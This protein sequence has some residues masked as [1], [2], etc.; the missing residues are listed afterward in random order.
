MP[1]SPVRLTR[2]ELV[3]LAGLTGAAAASS[4][5][6]SALGR[7]A[8]ARSGPEVFL[9]EAYALRAQIATSADLP[10]LE[11]IY[12]RSSSALRF[13]RDRAQYM[14]RGLSTRWDGAVLGHRS[15]ITMGAL[16]VNG[17]QAHARLSER[18]ESF[19][20][21]NLRPMSGDA[22]RLRHDNPQKYGVTPI[23]PRGEVAS[24]ALIP[25]EVWLTQA[26]G[27]WRIEKDAHDEFF[28][29]DRSPDLEPGSWAA[30]IHGRPRTVSSRVAPAGKVPGLARP[31]ATVYNYSPAAARAYAQGYAINPH[32][33]YC[34]YNDCGG[35]CTNFVSQC[36]RNGGE[37]DQS[38][39]YTFTGGC[40]TCG[41]S[42]TYAGSDTWANVQ[43]MGDFMLNTGGRASIRFNVD[44]IGYGDH[45]D[46]QWDSGWFDHKTILTGNP[47][48][49]SALVCSHSP[50][51]LDYS[52]N[53]SPLCCASAYRFIW[54]NTSYN[55]P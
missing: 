3:R 5:I 43:L 39:W 32:G 19:W 16:E 40:G 52:W 33:S 11:R 54:M 14:A 23:G 42:A 53:I 41:T 15:T 2:R 38:P 13:E 36:C 25:H 4:S 7:P 21:P 46:Y 28:L 26:G 12:D 6:V 18:L 55:Y 51:L 1:P 31:N 48:T 49:T 44:A 47:F 17:S 27:E 9:A 8:V 10:A 20:V 50:F 37:I 29:Y 45:I 35:D 22:L 30:I 24:M 34:N